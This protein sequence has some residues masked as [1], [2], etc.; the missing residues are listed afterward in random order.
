MNNISQKF[1]NDIN[2]YDYPTKHS[3][4]VLTAG[5]PSIKPYSI[6]NQVFT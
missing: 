5:K 3:S 6:L 2:L 4:W 1:L